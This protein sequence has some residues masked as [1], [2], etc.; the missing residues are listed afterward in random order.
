MAAAGSLLKG[1]AKRQHRI[2]RGETG[3][4]TSPQGFGVPAAFPLT[5]RPASWLYVAAHE[6]GGSEKDTNN[7]RDPREPRVHTN[8]LSYI[9]PHP[10]SSVRARF[11]HGFLPLNMS[12]AAVRLRFS[13]LPV[14]DG[15]LCSD[16]KNTNPP[17]GPGLSPPRGPC[18]SLPSAALRGNI[19][20]VLYLHDNTFPK[21][22]L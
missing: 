7:K 19:L 12:G 1:M 14:T 13:G 3:S 15:R 11:T 9:P 6:A 22:R 10:R 18:E 17:C 2:H 8:R 5:A 20:R 4:V 16:A 21:N